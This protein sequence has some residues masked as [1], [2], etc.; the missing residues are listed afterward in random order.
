MADILV[1][2][3]RP[4]FE[5]AVSV[6]QPPDVSIGVQLVRPQVNVE[7]MQGGSGPPTAAS[8]F[9]YTQNTPATE[10]SVAHP[11]GARP[12]S[13]LLIDDAGVFLVPDAVEI[14]AERVVLVFALPTAGSLTLLKGS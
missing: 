8:A 7:V 6:T 9:V 10:W 3:N 1:E 13:L 5:V 2:I 14:S 4:T 11:F 12:A